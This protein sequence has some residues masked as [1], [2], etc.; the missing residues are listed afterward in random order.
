[1]R[2]MNVPI[3]AGESLSAS[4]LTT[5][6]IPDRESLLAF[7]AGG[8]LRFGQWKKAR[9]MFSLLLSLNPGNADYRIALGLACFKDGRPEES[10]GHLDDTIGKRIGQEVRS[11]PF[12]QALLLCNVLRENG[13]ASEALEART[14]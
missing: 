1:M 13:M 12:W 8:Y 2:A 4:G 3:P 14:S 11:V 7:L 10:L 9:S 6:A 5:E